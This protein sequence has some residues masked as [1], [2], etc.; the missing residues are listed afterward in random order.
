[1][2]DGEADIVAVERRRLVII[3]VKTRHYTLKSRYPAL[4]AVDAEK[5]LRLSKL[6]CTFMRNNGP[7][8]RRLAIKSRRI[9]AVEVYYRRTWFGFLKVDAVSWHRGLDPLGP[10]RAYNG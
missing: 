7:L 5:R 10:K 3:E 9:D 6:A 1:M 8:C 2:T 4:D